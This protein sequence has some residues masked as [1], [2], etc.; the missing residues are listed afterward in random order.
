[1]GYYYYAEA[2]YHNPGDLFTFTYDGSVC[3]SSGLLVSTVGFSYHMYGTTM[4]TLSLVD[5]T[6]TAV[7]SLSGNQGV[8]WLSVTVSLFCSSFRFE[9]VRGSNYYGDAAVAQVVVSCAAAPPSPPLLPPSP[10]PAPPCPPSPPILPP[11]PQPPAPPAPPPLPP[12]IA[13]AT[14]QE[15]RNAIGL[16][17]STV[18]LSS[19]TTYALNGTQLVIRE[20]ATVTIA[21]RGQGPRA[22][23]N[24]ER[25]SRIFA[26]WGSLRLIGVDLM[27]GLSSD[28]S[29]D[30][31]GGALVAYYYAASVFITGSV[32][33]DCAAWST[34]TRVSALHRTAASPDTQALPRTCLTHAPPGLRRWPRAAHSCTY[35]RTAVRSWHKAVSPSS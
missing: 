31:S 33:A 35:R 2:S 34:T 4:G 18:L 14:T 29:G 32:I 10:P 6:G 22:V 8:T 23:I 16:G 5:A 26:V 19:G 15:L 28:E 3:T 21:T 12:G 7:W 27:L 9:Y 20:G 1:M 17:N 30:A 11:L 13:V 24:G 25:R